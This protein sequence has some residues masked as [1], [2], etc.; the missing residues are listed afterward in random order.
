MNIQTGNY[1][2]LKARW[3][4]ACSIEQQKK[5]K[6]SSQPTANI[7]ICCYKNKNY[8]WREVAPSQNWKYKPWTYLEASSQCPSLPFQCTWSATNIRTC[9][10]PPMNHKSTLPRGICTSHVLQV[11][12]GLLWAWRL[13]LSAW[14]SFTC[15][16]SS[17]ARLLV[18]TIMPHCKARCNNT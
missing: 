13:L 5:I 17:S 7:L 9:C 4:H 18:V 11:E 2:R 15:L 14:M 3:M 10:T 1:G 8:F 6:I 16:V 12:A